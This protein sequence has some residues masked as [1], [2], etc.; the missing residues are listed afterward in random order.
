M[1]VVPEAPVT[2]L[3]ALGRKAAEK[4]WATYVIVLGPTG[5]SPSAL[6]SFGPSEAR[7]LLANQ[8]A[9]A[10]WTTTL[11]E[12]GVENLLAL[13]TQHMRP[14][15]FMAMLAAG[16]AGLLGAFVLA[17]R[18]LVGAAG[19]LG[20]NDLDVSFAIYEDERRNVH[21]RVGA[22]VALLPDAFAH[23]A[24]WRQEFSRPLGPVRSLGGGVEVT[25]D[26][27]SFGA[28]FDHDAGLGAWKAELTF[29]WSF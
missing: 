24:L 1:T 14:E 28:S 15:A 25:L 6:F 3:D 29:K 26:E 17:P 11:T 23:G 16:A 2:K 27:F 20:V 5:T 9:Q 8:R 18:D 10:T 13:V 4:A 7:R 21:V 22:R 19:A 12:A